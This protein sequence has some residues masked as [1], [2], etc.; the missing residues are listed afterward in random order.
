MVDHSRYERSH[1]SPATKLGPAPARA[2]NARADGHQLN[3]TASAEMAVHAM[4]LGAAPRG[5]PLAAD[6]IR[7]PAACCGG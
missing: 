1:F 5:W 7:A 3:E 6:P 2:F 4:S